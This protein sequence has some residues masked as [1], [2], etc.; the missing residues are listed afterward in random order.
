MKIKLWWS[1][2]GKDAKVLLSKLCVIA[3]KQVQLLALPKL[4]LAFLQGLCLVHLL[5]VQEAATGGQ[6]GRSCPFVHCNQ[7]NA[8]HH[9][10]KVLRACSEV[11]TAQPAHYPGI[12]DDKGVQVERQSVSAAEELGRH[13]RRRRRCGCPH[14]P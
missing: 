13:R 11:L 12:M 7:T 10:P 2:L 8:I 6:G 9:P 5:P 3:H 1:A 14:A 4:K